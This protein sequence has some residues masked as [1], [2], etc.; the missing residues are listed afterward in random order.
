MHFKKGFT[1]VELLVVIAIMATLSTIVLFG[2]TQ[3]I[4]KGKDASIKGN[5]A[6]LITA[7]E[8]YYKANND[9]YRGFCQSNV[10]INAFSQ[11][12]SIQNSSCFSGGK[13]VPCCNDSLNQWAACGKE[14]SDPEKAYCVDSRG[15]KKDIENINCINSIIQCP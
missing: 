1:L 13:G 10:A 7:G 4:N 8:V 9:D 3:Y 5:L 11:I 15:V 6:I 12:P 2:I 14:F